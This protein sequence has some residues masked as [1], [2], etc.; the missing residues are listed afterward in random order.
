MSKQASHLS[1]LN[2]T[3]ATSHQL[4]LWLKA[5]GNGSHRATSSLIGAGLVIAVP[6]PCCCFPTSSYTLFKHGVE[7]FYVLTEILEI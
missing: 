6:M 2:S 4:H 3:S 1:L 5:T 7:I